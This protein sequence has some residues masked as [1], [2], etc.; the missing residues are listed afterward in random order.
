MENAKI[1]ILVA[2]I[3][4]VQLQMIALVVG[5]VIILVVSNV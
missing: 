1:A 3:A 5:K 4:K 2:Y